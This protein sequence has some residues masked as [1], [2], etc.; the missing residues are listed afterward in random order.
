MKK[1]VSSTEWDTAGHRLKWVRKQLG[2]SQSEIADAFGLSL[3]GY[4]R[5]E[6]DEQEFPVR[7]MESLKSKLGVM[8]IWIFNGSGEPWIDEDHTPTHLRVPSKPPQDEG[9]LLERARN[10]VMPV[11]LDYELTGIKAVEVALVNVAK[12]DGITNEH[13]YLLGNAFHQ[14]KKTAAAPALKPSRQQIEAMVARA[15]NEQ[16]KKIA[17]KRF[18]AICDALYELWN[19]TG[20]CPAETDVRQLVEAG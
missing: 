7:L 4:Q 1:T 17:P 6:R 20:T 14:L 9:T 2:K 16:K 10:R 19:S 11:L 5:Y 15:I 13:L 8:P 18:K 3:K 12:V